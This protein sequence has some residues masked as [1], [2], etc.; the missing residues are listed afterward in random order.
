MCDQCPLD[1][2]E[3]PSPEAALSVLDTS[4]LIARV[5]AKCS[6]MEA[7]RWWQHVG[8]YTMSLH[9][10]AALEPSLTEDRAVSTAQFILS[11]RF[12]LDLT[13]EQ[14]RDAALAVLEGWSQ[15]VV[16]TAPR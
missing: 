2:P 11:E 16:L 5:Q 7:R 1:P 12:V 15:R 3:I 6:L 14:A 4:L 13:P 8:R 9:L 10:F